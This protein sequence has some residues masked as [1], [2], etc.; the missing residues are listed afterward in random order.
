M[1]IDDKY[2]MEIEIEDL[3]PALMEYGRLFYNE[4]WDELVES[5][6]SDDIFNTLFFNHITKLDDAIVFFNNRF[7]PD[8]HGQ[9]AIN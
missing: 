2:R 3:I 6:T 5:Y 8:H 7:N 4:G 9:S 1:E